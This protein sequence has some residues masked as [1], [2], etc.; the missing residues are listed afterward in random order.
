MPVIEKTLSTGNITNITGL[1]SVNLHQWCVRG[2]IKPVNQVKGQGAYRLFNVSSVVGVAAAVKLRD[3]KRGCSVAFAGDVIAAFEKLG[4][5]RLENE[6]R[7]GNTHFTGFVTEEGMPDLE[8]KEKDWIDVEEIVS[9][10]AEE[11]ETE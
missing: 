2:I 8:K 6:I 1:N 3:S 4:M 11:A 9:R 7:K 5:K 10:V